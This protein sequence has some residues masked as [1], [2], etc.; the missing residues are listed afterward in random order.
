MAYEVELTDEFKEWFE[1]D[2]TAPEQKS[3]ARGVDLL[4][5]IGPNLPFPHSSGIS[6]SRYSHMRELRIQHQGRP[7][8]GA[9]RIRSAKSRN[10]IDR[11]GQDG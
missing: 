3:V 5:Q 6:A 1:V 10:P 9:L 7:L 4:E 8:S 2:L 11:R